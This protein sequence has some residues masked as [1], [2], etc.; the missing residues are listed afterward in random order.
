MTWS[1]RRSPL[2]LALQVGSLTLLWSIL[3]VAYDAW[4]C[5]QRASGSARAE[6]MALF[7]AF[8]VGTVFILV[9]PVGFVRAL[10][11]EWA[12]AAPL[13]RLVIGGLDG[14]FLSYLVFY[15]QRYE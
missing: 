8:G 6:S 15:R 5:Q 2:S 10:L 3:L 12:L 1:I 11:R 4:L 13:R 14:A 9:F 7:G